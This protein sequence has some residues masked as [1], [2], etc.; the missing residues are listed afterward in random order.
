MVT[1]TEAYWT[2]HTT[3]S[4]PFR[5]AGESLA[6]LDWRD[7][8]YPLFHRLMGLWGDHS[9]HTVLD[10]GCGPGNDLV[11]FLVHG[12]AREAIGIDASQTALD[13]AAS[14]LALHG[15]TATLLKVSDDVPV[16]PL[17][18]GSVDHIYCQ[19]VL[20]HVSHPAEILAEFHRVL[21][22]T[23]DAVVMVYNPDSIHIRHNFGIADR[24]AAIDAFQRSADGGAPVARTWSRAEFSALCR[25]FRVEYRGGFYTQD[26]MAAWSGPRLGFL[27]GLRDVGGFPYRGAYPAGLGAVYSLRP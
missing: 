15:L 27:S 4:E 26:E 6:Y 10:Y 24:A 25:G 19:G 17:P 23:G 22:P 14:R 2:H 13:L 11:G 9:E 21:R 20:H 7:T 3:R 18:D 5:S 8:E 1:A 12:H 16:V